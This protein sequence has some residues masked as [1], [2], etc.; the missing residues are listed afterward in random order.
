MHA[1]IVVYDELLWLELKDK[2]LLAFSPCKIA[3]NHD[4]NR[5]S[6]D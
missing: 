6:G 5:F 3:M 4:E 2:A 1:L